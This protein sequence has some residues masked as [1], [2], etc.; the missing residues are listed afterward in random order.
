[1]PKRFV[2]IDRMSPELRDKQ[3]RNK[4]IKIEAKRRGVLPVYEK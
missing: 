3:R 4:R 2:D 1:M